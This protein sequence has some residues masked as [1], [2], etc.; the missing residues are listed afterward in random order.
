[1][2]ELGSQEIQDM[3]SEVFS[4]AFWWGQKTLLAEVFSSHI[5]SAIQCDVQKT[6]LLHGV[7]CCCACLP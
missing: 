2:V 6:C 3:A 1:M 7:F 4:C 5:L